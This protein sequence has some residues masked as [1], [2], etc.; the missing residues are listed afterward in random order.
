MRALLDLA[1]PTRCAS[2]GIDSDGDL[3]ATCA[4]RVVAITTPICARC[5]APSD[6]PVDACAQC[7]RLRGFARARSVVTYAEPARSITL[8]LKWRGTRELAS[9][10][11]ALMAGVAGRAD[12]CGEAVTFVPGGRRARGAGFDQ[13]ELLARG[14]GRSMNLPVRRHLFRVREGPRQADVP[15]AERRANVKGRFGSRRLSGTVLLIDDVYTTGA[16]AQ[17][18]ALAL[19]ESGAESVDVVTWAR[20]VRRR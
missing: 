19:L 10:M 20:T 15:M 16:T 14:V 13:A 2:C 1:A 6:A 17:V 12:L 4:E 3:C 7:L 18:C 5:G 8:A 11:S 9:V